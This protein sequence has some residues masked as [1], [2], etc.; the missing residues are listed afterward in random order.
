ML[1][2]GKERERPLKTL[3]CKSKHDGIRMKSSSGGVFSLLA[4][5][6]INEGGVV[7]GAMFD[8]RWEV[9]HGWAGTIE[10]LERLRGSKYVQSRMEDCYG[11]VKKFLTE[12]R[13]VMFTGTPCQVAG[14]KRFLHK[15]YDKLL[16]VDIVCHG[17]P[18]PKVW[19]HYLEGLRKRGSFPL[20]TPKEKA[21]V[22]STETPFPGEKM[23]VGDVTFRDKC[24][25]WKDY[26]VTVT[27]EA[28][29]ENGEKDTLRLS[30]LH[31]EDAY[32]QAFIHNLC[33]R[34]SCHNC[35]AKGGSSLSDITLADHWGVHEL[36]PEYDDDRGQGLVILHTG[37]GE[38]A[39]DTLSM[40]CREV[41]LE[42]SLIYNP[43]Y[44]TSAPLSQKR[45]MFFSRFIDGEEIKEITDDLLRVSYLTQLKNR[46][47]GK[48]R[49]TFRR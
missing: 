10:E 47:T 29:K 19:R 14:L 4:E 11:K 33:L 17:V 48:I 28:E 20:S 34:P 45:D 3:S 22:Q 6:C 5:K 23:K 15:E 26:S 42:K 9:R 16:T 39:L 37:K 31:G 46:I 7:F 27:L 36:Y 43:A 13:N 12:G 1:H 41:S 21:G 38:Q 44:R 35:P 18:S 8:D 24:T 40:E 25:G 2:P 32:M 49:R 30:H